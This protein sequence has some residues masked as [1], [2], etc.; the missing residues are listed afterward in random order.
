MIASEG[1]G[2]YEVHYTFDTDD[3]GNWFWVWCETSG[4]DFPSEDSYP[5]LLEAIEAAIE[6][7]KAVTAS[8]NRLREPLIGSLED[9]RQKELSGELEGQ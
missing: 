5:T 8:T 2:Q 9:L 4:Q 1:I 3:S 7:V 6:D